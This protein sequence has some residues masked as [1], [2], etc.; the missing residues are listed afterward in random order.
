MWERIRG[1]KY[2][3]CSWIVFSSSLMKNMVA[4]SA[5]SA[6]EA[7]GAGLRGVWRS[8]RRGVGAEVI[9]QAWV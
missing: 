1:P 2:E 7:G 5:S 6:L 9:E 8:R 4:R 3:G